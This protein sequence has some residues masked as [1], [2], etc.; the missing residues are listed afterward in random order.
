MRARVFALAAALLFAGA[1]G[2]RA[3][4]TPPPVLFYGDSLLNLSKGALQVATGNYPNAANA[5][6]RPIVNAYPGSALCQWV[7]Q[8]DRDITSSHARALVVAFVGNAYAPCVGG[9]SGH[10]NPDRDSAAPTSIVSRYRASLQQVVAVAK[11]RGIRLYVVGPIQT[12][13]AH[14]PAGQLP[15]DNTRLDAVYR[16]VVQASGGTAVYEP[17]AISQLTPG[18]VW[19]ARRPCVP[20]E[21]GCSGGTVQVRPAADPLHLTSPAGTLRYAVGVSALVCAQVGVR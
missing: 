3:A 13:W 18:L 7:P 17:T 1:A 2:G 12:P 10:V 20:G 11:R 19:A 4:V 6:I 14:V 21:A 5:R 16:E 9:S 8:M 15:W